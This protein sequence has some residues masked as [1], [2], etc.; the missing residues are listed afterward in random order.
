MTTAETI[1]AFVKIFEREAI[2][3]LFDSERVKINSFK[4]KT[5]L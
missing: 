2:I 5:S 4:G 3:P 1:L